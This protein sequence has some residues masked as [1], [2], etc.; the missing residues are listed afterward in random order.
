M[1]L[2]VAAPEP[3]IEVEKEAELGT[4]VGVVSVADVDENVE[5]DA[6]RED[7]VDVDGIDDA[8]DVESEII[9]CFEELRMSD[10][11]DNDEAPDSDMEEPG[12]E[13]VSDVWDTESDEFG[14]AKLDISGVERAEVGLTSIEELDVVTADDLSEL[15]VA[16]PAWVDVLPPEPV[17]G[18]SADSVEV[19]VLP[20]LSSEL[21]EL[22]VRDTLD[23]SLV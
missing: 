7:E 6:E 13:T 14:V 2:S 1:T 22:C 5:S 15:S 17:D 11:D 20:E 12:P 18:N 8:D 9:S 16:I 10:I 3:G 19:F 4:L 23:S 21:V